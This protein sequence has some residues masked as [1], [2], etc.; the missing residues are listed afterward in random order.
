MCTYVH[1]CVRAGVRAYAC[2]CVCV[3]SYVCVCVYVCICL[4][5]L[6]NRIQAFR[7]STCIILTTGSVSAVRAFVR[8]VRYGFM[9]LYRKYKT[10]DATHRRMFDSEIGDS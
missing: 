7:M 8:K 2:A 6:N 5:E 3:V 9:R 1:V 10:A 4:Y